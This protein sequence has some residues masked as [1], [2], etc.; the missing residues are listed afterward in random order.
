MSIVT[1]FEVF[2]RKQQSW[3]ED[4]ASMDTR[5]LNDFIQSNP[6]ARIVS[7][8]HSGAK[9]LFIVYEIDADG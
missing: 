3:S 8:F 7:V 9:H 6:K 2:E 1:K 5:M 4:S